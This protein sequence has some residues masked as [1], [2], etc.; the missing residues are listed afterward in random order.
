MFK[1]PRKAKCCFPKIYAGA[2]RFQGNPASLTNINA[3]EW[4]ATLD[5]VENVRLW[6][7]A[8]LLEVKCFSH[9]N[10]YRGTEYFQRLKEVTRCMRRLDSLGL[11]AMLHNLR[12]IWEIGKWRNDVM[13]PCRECV[14]IALRRIYAGCRIAVV[15]MDACVKSGEALIGTLAL[16]HNT[17]HAVT[18]LALVARLRVLAGSMLTNLVRLYNTFADIVPLLTPHP[19][20]PNMKLLEC[21]PFSLNHKFESDR[22]VLWQGSPSPECNSWEDRIQHLTKE[23]AKNAPKLTAPPQTSDQ[24]GEEPG[25]ERAIQGSNGIRGRSGG[26]VHPSF[27]RGLLVNQRMGGGRGQ[28]GVVSL[29]NMM[30]GNRHGHPMHLANVFEQRGLGK[31]FGCQNGG[32]AKR[33]AFSGDFGGAGQHSKLMRTN[34]DGQ[35]GGIQ[36]IEGRAGDGGGASLNSECSKGQT[37]PCHPE[38]NRTNAGKNLNHS[39]KQSPR[40]L[41][42]SAPACQNDPQTSE[43]SLLSDS[44]E[45]PEMQVKRRTLEKKKKRQSGLPGWGTG[46]KIGSGDAKSWDQWFDSEDT[47]DALKKQIHGGHKSSRKRNSR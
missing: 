41:Q 45:K 2:E 26:N 36:K 25:L 46:G 8:A 47:G 17:A 3:I 18:W 24:N 39:I 14:A 15:L 30:R 28:T 13:L 32:V 21:L 19:D 10:Q 37:T 44:N 38:G 40:Q 43:K 20:K 5:L 42:K 6:K 35:S 12:E 1:P 33:K 23:I 9:E 29:A 22:A 31:G 16:C 34:R 27:G 11:T 7:E 4:E